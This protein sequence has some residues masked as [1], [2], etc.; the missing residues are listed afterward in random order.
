MYPLVLALSSPRGPVGNLR[1]CSDLLSSSKSITP[2]HCLCCCVLG[3]W[4]FRSSE[5]EIAAGNIVNMEVTNN[6]LKVQQQFYIYPQPWQQ[7]GFRQRYNEGGGG[8]F[9]SLHFFDH[10]K[11][12]C[13]QKGMEALLYCEYCNNINVTSMDSVLGTWMIASTTARKGPWHD[14]YPGSLGWS[15]LQAKAL[16]F[17]HISCI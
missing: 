13:P 16:S 10:I 11:K 14:Q 17:L 15:K 5:K 2:L 9:H 12:N 8:I 1:L 6:P 3:Y 7:Q 4:E